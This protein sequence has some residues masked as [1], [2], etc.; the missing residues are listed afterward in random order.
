[1]TRARL[2]KLDIDVQT[3]APGWKTVPGAAVKARRAARQAIAMGGVAVLEG[4]AIAISLAD[5]A[6]V[7]AA[8]RQWRATDKPTNVLSFPAAPPERIG[9]TPFLG[10]VILA[11][12]TVAAEAEAEGK[13]LEHHLMHLVAHGVLHLIGYDH[14]TKTEAER[15]ER[16]EAVILA[17]L[18][19]TD[20]YEGSEPLETRPE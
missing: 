19:I 14:M 16:L 12:E 7:R 11:H 2:P 13:P 8:N 1:V 10:D 5:D 20:P 17:A 3:A 9:R 15:M 4:A 18:G 6:R